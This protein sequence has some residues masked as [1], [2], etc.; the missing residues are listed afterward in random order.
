LPILLSFCGIGL[1][2]ISC[3]LLWLAILLAGSLAHKAVLAYCARKETPL[4]SS[5]AVYFL[6]YAPHPTSG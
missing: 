4:Q 5:Q 2:F 3:C 6:K 1:V